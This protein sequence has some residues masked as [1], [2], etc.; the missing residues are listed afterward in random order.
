MKFVTGARLVRVAGGSA[1]A[2]VPLAPPTLFRAAPV[3]VESIADAMA[4]VPVGVRPAQADWWQYDLELEVGYAVETRVRGIALRDPTRR[5]VVIDALYWDTAAGRNARPDDPDQAN[6]FLHRFDAKSRGA[7]LA[8]ARAALEAF[9]V[10]SHFNQAI[11]LDY[12]DATIRT[13]TAPADDPL[14][15]LALVRDLDG[16][17]TETPRRWRGKEG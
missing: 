9:V 12:R 11:P 13:S 3:P 1:G 16:A 10:R 7:A 5:T 17:V 6:T 14:G 15:L 2:K 8:V 4:L